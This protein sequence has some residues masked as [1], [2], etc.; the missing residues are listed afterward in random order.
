MP[1]LDLS[2]NGKNS[3]FRAGSLYQYLGEEQILLGFRT[4]PKHHPDYHALRLMDM[5][6]D[7]SVAGL[8]NLDLVEKQK[9][10]SAGCF[11]QNLNDHGVHF[12]YG[13]PKEG[14]ELE[15]VEKLLLEQINRVKKREIF[16]G[17]GHFA[18]ITD[19]KK[20]R[21]KTERTMQKRVELM[22]DTFLSFVDWET[23]DQEIKELEKL[24]KQ[25]II[26]VAN[27]YYGENGL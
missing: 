6:I 8:I 3:L 15:D 24:T 5:V 23:T 17:L 20:W 4:A 22:R 26:R 11:P 25:D 19:F 10:R 21:R 2:Q 7:N 18:V 13:V 16:S 9:V 1:H 14:Q 27:Q 12:F